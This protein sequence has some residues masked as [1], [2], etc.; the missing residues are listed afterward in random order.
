MASKVEPGSN[1]AA[2]SLFAAVFIANWVSAEY[3][4]YPFAWCLGKQVIQPVL[5]PWLFVIHF[6][7]L[8]Y[9]MACL[10]T[11]SVV[12]IA[13]GFAVVIIVFGIPTFAETLF[14]LGKS[15]S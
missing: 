4:G 8:A 13:Q 1:E 2:V 10:A 6:M 9:F 3:Y 12:N 7:A 11:R 14:R 15:C 5:E